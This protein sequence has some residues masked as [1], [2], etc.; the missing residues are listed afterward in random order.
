MG[1][2]GGFSG[3]SDIGGKGGFG[4]NGVIGNESVL[5]KQVFR[6]KGENKI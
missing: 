1:G 3:I 5:T 6:G 2:K 4:G